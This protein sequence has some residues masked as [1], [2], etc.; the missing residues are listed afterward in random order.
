MTR[1]P[2]PLL[3][4]ICVLGGTVVASTEP[5]VETV[6]GVPHVRNDAV[7]LHGERTLPLEEIWSVDAEAEEE[8]IGRITAVLV[9]PDGTVYLADWQLG[10]VLVYSAAGRFLRTLSRQG[11]G[12]G[13]IASPMNLLWLPDGGLGILDR[14]PGQ[15]THIDQEGVPQPSVR[16]ASAAGE[17]LA[18]A[19]LSSARCGGGILAVCGTTFRARPGFD[20]QMRFLGVF[21]AEGR[22]RLR[23]REAPS[24][25][26]FEARSYDEQANWFAERDLFDVD[27][28]GNVYVVAERD[29]YRIDV[30]GPDGALRRV[31]ERRYEPRRRTAEELDRMSGRV[32]M[33]INGEIVRLRST[34]APFAPA[35]ESLALAGDGRLWVQPGHGRDSQ[36]KDR[37]GSYDIFDGDGRFVETVHLDVLVDRD[38]DRLWFLGDGRWLLLRNL[39]SPDD[40]EEDGPDGL[41]DRHLQIVCLRAAAS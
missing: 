19:F 18:T 26:D 13:E 16:L 25:F 15:I 38:R 8:L 1:R 5:V 33:S 2:I 21:D 39:F 12:P 35:I 27:R 29:R 41:D 4:A 36:R 32:S 10:Q 22:E 23:L 24:G 30:H 34:F 9:G 40:D 6:D 37:A 28:A 17:P 7:P 11:E 31:I 3:A 14:K 20:T